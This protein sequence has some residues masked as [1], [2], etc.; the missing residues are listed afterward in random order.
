MF[1]QTEFA[2]GC[3]LPPPQS[4][5]YHAECSKPLPSQFVDSPRQC[6][7]V[8]S[9]CDCSTRLECTNPSADKLF[10]ATL[11]KEASGVWTCEVGGNYYLVVVVDVVTHS[12]A[13]SNCVRAAVVEEILVF[14][15]DGSGELCTVSLDS[16][17]ALAYSVVAKSTVSQ[18][19]EVTAPLQLVLALSIISVTLEFFNTKFFHH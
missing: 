9:D 11:T 12:A 6:K 15:L 14:A 4:D 5:L 1:Q 13:V 17:G 10:A 7:V 3:E 2:E 8:P 18:N 16:S 19:T